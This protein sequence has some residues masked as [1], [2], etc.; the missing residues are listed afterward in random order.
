[1]NRDEIL[2]R[3]RQENQ[4]ED[5]REQFVDAKA[6]LFSLSTMIIL[7][8]VLCCI[9][10]FVHGGTEVHDLFALLWGTFAVRYFYCLWK[11]RRKGNLAIALTTSALAI[12]QFILYILEGQPNDTPSCNP[13]QGGHRL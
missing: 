5:E 7:V 6:S 3:S 8:V 10:R 13:T 4:P 9:R 1:M 11:D 12:H 2:A